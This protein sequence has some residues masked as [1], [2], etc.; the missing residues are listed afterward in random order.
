M[1]KMVLTKLE[2]FCPA[3]ET[4]N[5]TK[6]NKQTK[7]PIYRLREYICKKCYKNEL[8]FKIYKYIHQ[9]QKKNTQTNEKSG[10]NTSGQTEEARTTNLQSAEQKPQ[11]QKVRQMERQRLMSQM[12]KQDESSEKLKKVE[13]GKLPAKEL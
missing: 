7:K 2:S 3:K 9:Y 1:N 4:I 5:K 10:Q 6:T 11:S 12:K 8:I 13:I